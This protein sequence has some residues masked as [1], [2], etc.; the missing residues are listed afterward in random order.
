MSYSGAGQTKLRYMGISV[1]PMRESDLP[2]VSS[3]FAASLSPRF[4]VWGMRRHSGRIGD[5]TGTRWRANP[6]AALKAEVNGALAGSNFEATWGSFGFFGPLTIR[7]ELW[8][9]GIGAASAGF[10]ATMDLFDAWGI[11]EAGLFTFAQ[12]PKHIGLY[13]KF[14][15]WPRFLTAVM[16]KAVGEGDATGWSKYSAVLESN[17][18]GALKACSDLTDSI[19]EG[20]DV[21][22]EIE[23]VESQGFAGRHGAVVGRRFA[24]RVCGLSLRRGDRSGSR[25]L[26]HK[27]CRG[28]AGERR[29]RPVRTSA[30]RLRSA[31]SGAR[32]ASHGSRREPGPQS[33]LSRHATA[34]F[35]LGHSRRGY[36]S[37][38]F[39]GV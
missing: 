34:R 13:Q 36:A 14:G 5:Y 28:P 3:I 19:F 38:Q 39:A 1:R 31:G 26:L 11:K 25:F 16:S 21:S 10:N 37:I 27:I 8:N 2:A 22:L 17:R 7:P 24:G 15:F 18:S 32:A 29:R 23:S 12:S 4:W 33:G 6:D 9:R 20:L 35:S 30:A